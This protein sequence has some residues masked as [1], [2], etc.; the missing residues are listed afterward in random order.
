MAPEF[1]LTVLSKQEQ[2]DAAN[3]THIQFPS[4]QHFNDFKSQVNRILGVVENVN[5]FPETLTLLGTTKLHGTHLDIVFIKNDTSSNTVEYNIYFQSRNRILSVEK[6]NIL[7]CT[8]LSSKE[9]SVYKQLF[10]RALEISK[11]S[12]PEIVIITGE[13]CGENVQKGVA[14]T[15]LEKLFAVFGLKVDNR[16]MP[17]ESLKYLEVPDARIFS[18]L[19][20]GLEQIRVDTKDLDSCTNKLVELTDN[21]EKNCPFAKS[22][23]VNGIGEGMVWQCN[24]RLTSTLWFKVK[25]HLHSVTKINTLKPQTPQEI[26][27]RKNLKNFV[28]DIITISRLEQG[29]DYLREHNLDFSGESIPVFMNW[30]ASDAEKEE[31][32]HAEALGLNWKKVKK[33]IF[34]RAKD[35]YKKTINKVNL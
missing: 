16:W 20:G 22:F 35:F 9:V 18:I 27:R 8:T 5:Q 2:I 14:L 31:R 1:N 34:I 26:E 32:A 17:L 11:V 7:S 21:V 33:E 28:Q 24:E 25:G 13:W 12:A 23:G 3:L 30:V 6:D 4:I 29:L 15:Q 10:E 19:R